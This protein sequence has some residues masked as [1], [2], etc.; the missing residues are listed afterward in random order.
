M[1]DRCIRNIKAVYS[2]VLLLDFVPLLIEGLSPIC[3]NSKSLF[4]LLIAEDEQ[5]DFIWPKSFTSY[6]SSCL[7][8]PLIN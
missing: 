7:K 4:F 6:S 1:V 5:A 3:V 2:S 8:L